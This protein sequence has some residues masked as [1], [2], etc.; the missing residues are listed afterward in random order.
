MTHTNQSSNYELPQSLA[1]PFAST[2][3]SKQ[4]DSQYAGFRNQNAKLK[5]DKHDLYMH[6]SRKV[7]LLKTVRNINNAKQQEIEYESPERR[8]EKEL[9]PFSRNLAIKKYNSIEAPGEAHS[10]QGL[11]F[12]SVKSKR[13]K[14]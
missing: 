5:K 13:D 10:S 11:D 1:D 2:G 6:K 12:L 9:E 8:K 7:Q 14:I 4:V 3:F